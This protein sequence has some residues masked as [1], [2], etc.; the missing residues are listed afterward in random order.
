MTA[1]LALQDV[2]YF[3]Q[4]QEDCLVTVSTCNSWQTVDYFDTLVYVLGNAAGPGLMPVVACN[5]DAC[6]KLSQLQVST[7]HLCMCTGVGERAAAA[8]CTPVR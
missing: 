4:P 3:F 6:S 8:S 7:V 1:C 2:V 5:D